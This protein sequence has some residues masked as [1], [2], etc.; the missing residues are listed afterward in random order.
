M[1]N[2]L[3]LLKIVYIIFSINIY[4]TRLWASLTQKCAEFNATLIVNEMLFHQGYV[5]R[6]LKLC[7][8]SR[9]GMRKDSTIEASQFKSQKGEEAGWSNTII[10]RVVISIS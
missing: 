2:M 6:T 1:S 9:A 4:L 8:P 5:C 3:N 7:G 10:I